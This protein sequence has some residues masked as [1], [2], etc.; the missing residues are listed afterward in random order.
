MG[1]PPIQ[2]RATGCEGGE[3]YPVLA[4]AVEGQF[5]ADRRPDAGG[6]ASGFVAFDAPR[7]PFT[8]EFTGPDGK[9]L[10]TWRMPE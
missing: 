1:R 4:G 5:A 10:L 8:L 6:S 7:Q 9:A 2:L 3:A